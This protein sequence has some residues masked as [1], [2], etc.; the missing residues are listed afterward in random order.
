YAVFG[1]V[2]YRFSPELKL[3]T[4]LRWYKYETVENYSQA[5]IGTASGNA[6]AT[7]GAISSAARGYNPKVNLSYTPNADLT[8]YG[9]IARGFRPGGV[10]LPVPTSGLT[11]CPD[12][13]L[14]YGPDSVWN[15][16]VG[17]KARFLDN[18]LVINSDV[19]YIK[20]DQIQQIIQL[21]C[22]YP[23]TANAGNA[24]SYGPEVEVTG[25]ITSR[26]TVSGTAAWTHSTIVHANPSSGIQDGA[27]VLN[28]PKET[29]SLSLNYDQPV[30]GTSHWISR[31]TDS[32]VGSVA[33]NAFYHLT[34]PSYNL[35]GL[36]SG[37]VR[38]TWS[39]YLFVD[40]LTDKHAGLTVNNT[41]FAWQVPSITR[42]TTNQPRT[43][44]VDLQYRF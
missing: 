31:I 40:N 26:F 17:E 19:Y 13:P 2:S 8:L 4:G 37:I 21:S 10:S 5:G 14:T 20:W 42:V 27:R 32:Y 41:S 38:G 34:L 24:R 28:I 44:G 9:T 7:T 39:A 3:T 6:Q 18:K 33:D 30:L 25:K 12:V 29:A 22:G 16:E 23:Y 43:V 15:Y 35:I 11:V 1:D 36:R